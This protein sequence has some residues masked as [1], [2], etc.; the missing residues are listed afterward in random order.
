MRTPEE[1]AERAAN[2]ADKSGVGKRF[3]LNPGERSTQVVPKVLDPGEP[4]PSDTKA[5]PKGA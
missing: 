5:F 1:E 3:V 4:D 2:R